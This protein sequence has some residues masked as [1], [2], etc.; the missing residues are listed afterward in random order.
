MHGVVVDDKTAKPVVGALVWAVRKKKQNANVF[1]YYGYQQHPGAVCTDAR[2]RFR[3]HGLGKG[4]HRVHAQHA[5]HPDLR[6]KE[7]PAPTWASHTS[8]PMNTTFSST[9]ASDTALS[10]GASC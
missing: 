2:G 8:M 1:S 9:M 7:R 10:T 3:L 5:D 6:A 4:R